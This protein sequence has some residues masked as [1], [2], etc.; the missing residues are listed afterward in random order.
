MADEAES[1]VS[2]ISEVVIVGNTAMLTLFAEEHYQL[3][4]K[5]EYWMQPIAYAQAMPRECGAAWGLAAG[6]RVELMPSLGG[7]VG[8]DLLA[9]LLATDLA[10]LAAGSL[11]IDFGTNSEIALWDGRRLWVTSAA[12]GPAFE[13]SGI[14]CAMP[15]ERGAV[16]RVVEQE[17][18]LRG[19]V[20]GGGPARGLCGSGLV[21][22]IALLV[23]SD[24]IT[25]LGKFKPGGIGR[26]P[27]FNAEF[28]AL[29]PRERDLDLFQRAKAAI[30][31]G[32]GCLLART[33]LRQEAL[34]RVCVCGAFG[35]HLDVAHAQAIGLLPDVSPEKVTLCGNTALA[36]CERLLFSTDRAADLVRLHDMSTLVSLAQA[37]SF[38]RLFVENLFLRPMRLL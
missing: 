36:G 7:F 32:V 24:I 13:G 38:E 4:L 8:S 10:G 12:G 28:A 37:P 34:Q 25:K 20:I 5:P 2:A 27:L 15:A 11:L 22:L 1:P 29:M 3:L 19:E 26:V 14:H 23:R 33:R 16:G 30:G 6:A 9:G 21:D 17:S 18:G 35:R 31:A